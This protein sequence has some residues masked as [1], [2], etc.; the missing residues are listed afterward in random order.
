MGSHVFRLGE[1]PAMAQAAKLANQLMLATN[2]MGVREG[3][4]IASAHGV[5]EE[6]LMGLLTVST[7][8]SWVTEHWRQVE[9]F[10]RAHRP[11]D[12]LD[13]ILKDLRSTLREADEAEL[14]LPLTAVAF[15]RLRSA[16]RERR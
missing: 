2:I 10:T 12:E 9:G 16:W 7:G 15:Q 1:R 8:G 13:I 3:L 11:G 5:D 14:S 4:E 6:Q